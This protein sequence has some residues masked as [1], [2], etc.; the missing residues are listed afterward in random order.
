MIAKFYC[1]SIMALVLVCVSTQ[2]AYA[3]SGALGLHGTLTEYDGDLNGNQHHFYDFNF[4]KPGAA[5]SLQQYLN[6]SFNLVEKFSFN[7]LRYQNDDGTLGVNA[8]FLVLNLKLKYKLNN[9]YLFKETAA[10]APFLVGGIGGTYVESSKYTHLDKSEISTG[11]FK[12]NI[13][14]GAGI[15]FQFNERIGLE[16]ANTINVPLFDAWDGVDQGSNDVYLQHSAGLVFNLRK[17]TDTDKDGVAD[18]KDNCPDTPSEASVDSKGCPIDTDKDDVPDYLDKCPSEVGSATLEGCPD[19]DRDN[20]SD[21]DDKCPDVPG[22]S[23]FAGC[24]DTDN[25]GVEDANDKCPN[26]AG[27]DAFQGCPDTDKDGVEDAKDKC[28]NTPAGVKVDAT[29]C[30]ADGDGDG[31]PDTED[32]CPTTPG[33]GT[34]NGCPEVKEEVKKRLNFATRGIYFETAKATLKPAS[35]PMLDEI[36]SILGEYT[37]YSLR[38]GGYTDSN[39]SDATNLKLSQ[40]RVNSVKAYLISKGVS[41]SRLEAIGYGET[42]PIASNKTAAGR[43]QNR[44]VELELFLKE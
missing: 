43:A 7:Q 28:A 8:E 30:P 18:R 10:I 1:L 32:R 14:F 11:E 23:R 37:D 36:V 33:G 2:S 15:L 13:A 40:A 19:K 42:K 35:Y 44:R 5:I 25:D 22:T 16:L 17:P 4:L 34:A 21:K 26:Q 39:G 41:E 12:G 27:L 3:Q 38:L 29:G 31:V 20:V 9:G 6:P 24:P